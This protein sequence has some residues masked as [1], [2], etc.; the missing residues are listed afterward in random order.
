MLQSLETAGLQVTHYFISQVPSI[1]SKVKIKYWQKYPIY[2]DWPP[3]PSFCL[4][5]ILL[6][7]L[8]SRAIPENS[9][10]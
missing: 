3:W 9:S 6:V 8:S 10:L 7:V 2:T 1:V 5:E 4:L